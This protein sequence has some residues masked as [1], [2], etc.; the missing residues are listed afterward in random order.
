VESGTRHIRLSGVASSTPKVRFEITATSSSKA[1]KKSRLLK[2]RS[3]GS[4]TGSI[5]KRL[6]D[7]QYDVTLYA[8]NGSK[9]KE[10]ATSTLTVGIPEATLS[11]SAIPLL[12]GGTAKAGTTVPISY[13]QVRNVSSSTVAVKGFW[14]VNNGSAADDAVVAFS[15]VDDQGNNRTAATGTL[16]NGKAFIPS[17]SVL[18]P[19][20]RRLFTLKAQ[21][22]PTVRTG[23][24]LMLNVASV[25]A[26]SGFRGSFPI[27]GTT[28]ALSY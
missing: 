7:G 1:I 28:W 3:D 19:G 14:V 12:G 13:L 27:L 25:D 20:E 10:I 16:H 9:K 15:S 4:W 6:K 26:A 5:S 24:T 23:T 2:V 18:A 17:T 8:V 21:I 11:V 22:A